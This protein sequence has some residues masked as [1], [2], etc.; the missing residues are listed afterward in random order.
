MDYLQPLAGCNFAIAATFTVV[1]LL[2]GNAL[3][4]LVSEVSRGS[5]E[6]VIISTIE[7]DGCF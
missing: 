2:E 4:G 5:G 1:Y 6:V 3:V 7:L